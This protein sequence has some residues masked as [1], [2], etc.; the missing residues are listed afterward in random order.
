MTRSGGMR[1][2]YIVWLMKIE[3][4]PPLAPKFENLHYGLWQLRRAI[5][6][7]PLKIRARCLH[8]IGGFRG[9]SNGIIQIT[10]R[11]TLVAMATS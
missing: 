4:Y 9:Q 2:L 11:P 3:I 6:R 10:V 7:A 8:Q 1:I 5:T